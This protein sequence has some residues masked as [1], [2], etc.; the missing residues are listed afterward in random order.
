MSQAA[1]ATTSFGD[2]PFPARFTTPLFIGSALNPINSSLIATALVPIAA[3][4]HVPVGQTAAL[5]SS[6]YV[7]SAIGQPTAGKAAEVLGPRR[8]FLTGIVLVLLGGL[9]GGFAPNLLVLL[10]SRIL[11]GLGTSCAYPTAMLLIRR[12]ARAAGLDQ[13][14]G[15]ILGGL[16]ISG[17]ATVSLGLPIGGVLVQFLGW[18]SV[19][20]IDVPVALIALIAT[21]IGV[22][23]DERTAHRTVGQ[24]LSALDIPGIIGFAASLASLLLFLSALPSVSGLLL[25]ITVVLWAATILW[26]LRAKA[27][28]FDL[29]LLATHGAL[30]RTLL[31]FGL[32]SLFAYVVMY[33]L[34]QW[35]EVAKGLPASFAGLVLLPMTVIGGSVVIPI[36]RRRLIR[37]PLRIAAVLSTLAA[38]GMLF[39][40]TTAWVPFAF[41]VVILVG[42][43]QGA[44]SS[45][46][47]A[48]YTQAPAE[49]LGTAAGLMRAFGYLGSIG[50]SA[51]T[52][53]VFRNH[54]TDGGVLTIA[55]I[56]LGVSVVLLALTVLDRTLRPT[57]AA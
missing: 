48:L 4:V 57:P 54:V 50:S 27:P 44:G 40:P 35:L 3:G 8:V 53:V 32:I 33:G 28:F 45:N 20:L 15:G 13:P 30:T 31:R 18:R 1:A 41:L 22:P 56:M 52:G 43:A 21:L 55:W 14:P 12:R 5:I 39:L 16:Q 2:R 37:G 9:V 46:Q 25:T 36:S 19:F 7:A 34:T 10:A 6:L 26:E 17:I 11:I 24:L 38:I 42:L 47:I 51:I 49:V 23:R 29:R